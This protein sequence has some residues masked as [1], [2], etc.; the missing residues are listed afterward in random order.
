PQD[1][2][3]A[4]R[5]I[6]D[7]FTHERKNEREIATW[8][9]A[10]GLRTDWNRPWTRAAVHS[11]LTNAKYA[12]CNVYNR[13]SFKLKRKHV[14]N[15]PE[16]WIRREGA[17]VPLISTEQFNEALV[18]IHGRSQHLSDEELLQRLRGLL[19]RCGTLSGILIDEAEDMPSS[20][21]YRHR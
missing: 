5:G 4:V 2:V 13:R 21:A 20:A 12:G 10:Q 6:F 1:E 9:N 18:I 15:P 7:R 17:F 16:M 11:I 19:Q 3:E 8:L 14:K